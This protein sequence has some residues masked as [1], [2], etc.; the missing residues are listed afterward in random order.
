M[1]HRERQLATLRHEETDRI[2]VDAIW[3]YNA[4]EIAEHSGIDVYDVAEHLGFDGRMVLLGYEGEFGFSPGGSNP[5]R[6][7]TIHFDGINAGY[8]STRKF[9]LTHASSVA[10]IE[11][12]EWPDLDL[13]LYD[14][15]AEQARALG[16]TY[17][18]RGPM[19][20]PLFCQACD[21]FGIE[22]TMIR[23]ATQPAMM[24]AFFDRIT[25]IYVEICGRLLDAC[26]DSM[27]IF[28]LGD[29]FAT[30]RGLMI[31]P[32][33]WRHFI[34]PRL[35]RI[36][37]VG[38]KRGK[39]VWYH[40]CGDISAVLPDLIDIGMDLWETV[41]LH[42]LPMSPRELKREYGQHISF[43]GGINTQKLPFASPE[44]IRE[45]V[46]ETIEIL[47]EGGGFICGGD[48]SIN[49]DVPPANAV[50]LYE[51]A[52]SFRREGYTLSAS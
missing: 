42:T 46:R 20:V 24:E 6:W 48:H 5:V 22:E 44:E 50:A 26:G 30:Q 47:G 23:M 13:F 10:D 28:F 36:F 43:F 25:D 11:A 35:A 27:P 21:L 15:A 33:M 40:S 37:E 16:E 19:W 12:F 45:E 9:A 38:K 29:D 2:S 17:A 7:S 32:A 14:A 41:Q 3:V 1:N 39:F 34:K 51:S 31:S 8:T 18:V 49:A 4:H 52:T